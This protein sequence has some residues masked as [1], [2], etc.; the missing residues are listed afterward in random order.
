[1]IVMMSLYF[2]VVLRTVITCRRISAL[3]REACD[4]MLM[5]DVPGL[6]HLLVATRRHIL[7]ARHS[8]LGHALMPHCKGYSAA[9][10]QSSATTSALNLHL[11]RNRNALLKAKY[12]RALVNYRQHRPLMSSSLTQYA[13]RIGR[14]RYNCIEGKVYIIKVGRGELVAR[15]SDDI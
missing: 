3:S 10:H 9:R 2:I 14:I 1:M 15:R 5:A 8:Q 12:K 6:L 4:I 7:N 13:A 11:C